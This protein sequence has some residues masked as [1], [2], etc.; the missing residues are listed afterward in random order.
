MGSFWSHHHHHHYHQ[1]H[2]HKGPHKHHHKRPHK[3]HHKKPHY[4]RPHK[5]PHHHKPPKVIIE[6][7]ENQA[8]FD[9][10]NNGGGIPVE[11]RYVVM[12][13]P[14][15]KDLPANCA[16]ARAMAAAQVAEESTETVLNKRA[17]EFEATNNGGK[18]HHH[19]H[20]HYR[21]HHQGKHHHVKHH[22]GKHRHVKHHHGKHRHGKHHHGKH[23][24]GKHYHGKHHHGK[25]HHGKHHH[26][27]GDRNRHPYKDLCV[28]IGD[29]CGSKLHGCDFDKTYY[30]C[31]AIGEPPFVNLVDAKVCGGNNEGES[32]CK[33][34]GDGKTPVCDSQLPAACNADPTM[35]YHCLGGADSK[36]EVFKKC[37]PGTV[38]IAN[39]GQ[40]ATCGFETCDCDGNQKYCSSQFLDR[41]GL[42]KNTV[43]SCVDGKLTERKACSDDQ[44]CVAVSNGAYC[45]SKDCKCPDDGTICGE[46]FPASCRLPATSLYT[47]KKGESP[48]VSE[49]CLPGYCT[50]SVAS[51]SAAVVLRL[52]PKTSALTNAL[53]EALAYGSSFAPRCGLDPKTI[54]TC[55]GSGSK[56][57]L[58][59][60]CENSCL[61]QA[62]S[63]ICAKSDC[64]CPGTGSDPVCGHG[65]PASCHAD[66][67][68]ICHCPG[69]KGSKPEVLFDCKPGTKCLKRPSPEGAVCGGVGCDCED[70]NEICSNQFDEN[71]GYEKST[72]YKCTPGGKPEKVKTCDSSKTC[73]SVSDG[74]GCGPNDCKC[75]EDG[76]TCGEIFP[77]S[78]RIKTIALYTC[79]KGEAPIFLKDCHPDYCSA[80]KAQLAAAAVFS[81]TA[82]D[83]CTD[84]CTCPGKGPVCGSTFKP[85]CNMGPSTLYNCDGIGGTPTPGEV[86]GQGGCTVT[87]GNDKCNPIDC[88]CPGTGNVPVCGSELPSS[89]NAL[90]NTIYW[91]P[92]G[93]GDTPKVLSQCKP[94]TMCMKKPA[95][96][97]AVCGA[98]NC[99]CIGDGEVC[100]NQ[101]PDEC[102]LEPN[103]IYK[104]T[105]NDNP[106]KVKTCDATLACINLGDEAACGS[107]DCKCPEDGVSCGQIFPLS[108][109]LK[110]TALYTCVKGADPVLKEDCYPNRCI[111]SKSQLEAASIF[112]STAAD[113]CVDKCTCGSKGPA[114][115]STFLP[116]CKLDPSTFYNCEGNGKIPIAGEVC[117]EGGCTVH[118]GDDKCS[119]SQCTC[120]G[121]GLVPV[122]GAELPKECNAAANTIYQ[123]PSSS[124]SQPEVLSVCLPG[125]MCIQKPE[126]A[127]CGGV[128]CNCLGDDEVCSNMFPDSC[129]YEKNAIYKCTPGGTPEKVE[130]CD[131]TEACVKLDD[132]PVCITTLLPGPVFSLDGMFTTYLSAHGGGSQAYDVRSTLGGSLAVVPVPTVPNIAASAP[133]PVAP[134]TLPPGPS[135]S[136]DGVFTTSL[137]KMWEVDPMSPSPVVPAAPSRAPIFAL[138]SMFKKSLSIQ[139]SRSRLVGSDIYAA[140]LP[141]SSESSL[142]HP[143]PLS[144]TTQASQSYSVSRSTIPRC[145]P[146]NCFTTSLS[147]KPH[148]QIIPPAL[149]GDPL[150]KPTTLSPAEVQE[151]VRRKR[152]RRKRRKKEKAPH[153][154]F[155]PSNAFKA[156]I[157]HHTSAPIDED[158]VEDDSKS[159]K[160]KTKRAQIYVAV[161]RTRRTTSKN[162]DDDG[163]GDDGDG[164]DDEAD[165]GTGAG[166]GGG[167]NGIKRLTVASLIKGTLKGKFTETALNIGTLLACLENG[168]RANQLDGTLDYKTIAK[169][170]QACI[171]QAVRVASEARRLV[172]L[173]HFYYVAKLIA[174]N[175]DPLNPDHIRSCKESHNDGQ[176]LRHSLRTNVYLTRLLKVATSATKHRGINKIIQAAGCVDRWRRGI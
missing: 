1:H 176:G 137:T 170:V 65:L 120:P 152:A 51:I 84:K 15:S 48:T 142:A 168:I 117:K 3:H 71:C 62:G 78:C 171:A 21:H 99:N 147:C 52:W 85:D 4:K 155:M 30:R 158:P 107:P 153:M 50:A 125:T 22:H 133:A 35:V 126:G 58:G 173:A 134:A 80:S 69:G 92:G 2:H 138:D 174:D 23:R 47:C 131:T 124:G 81:S 59:E 42:N 159:R 25:N 17:T 172:L 38:C 113:V 6:S 20:R 145:V 95:P 39:P 63:S 75:T 56:P 156:S 103:T 29:F 112:L 26:V 40:G 76:T 123:C 135:F 83:K 7:A 102:N 94:G 43:Y 114:C 27:G 61:V 118:N 11:Q 49:D 72:I 45:G 148:A 104:C 89:C 54:Y 121:T 13:S 157:Y 64:T 19:H 116:E 166:G 160:P 106:E 151:R 8:P 164:D 34:P 127:V 109:N 110:T 91:C 98:P 167:G 144:A 10:M 74:A 96:E 77:L 14:C 31:A 73:V 87:N 5:K 24:H 82:N 68:T 150:G 165:D 33:C 86:C 130:N 132:G 28:A 9:A 70:E 136:L 163:D 55:T 105:A 46:I 100:S 16:A 139:T 115:G 12:S 128:D 67:N 57:T 146:E 41:C 44:E 108:Y 141:A 32:D 129:G 122:C 60:Q 149:G 143:P 79:K 37:R 18:H 162:K 53:A 161:P 169:E 175:P 97:G 66:A 90:P 36:P 119:T 140:V 111:A 93:S 101:F 154:P 88:T